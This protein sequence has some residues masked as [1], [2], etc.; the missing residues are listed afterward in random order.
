MRR[1]EFLGASCS[2]AGAVLSRAGAPGGAGSIELLG[3][4]ASAEVI[5]LPDDTATAEHFVKA[6]EALTGSR[7]EIS[8]AG[9]AAGNRAAVLIGDIQ[10][11]PQVC[12][13]AGTRVSRMTPESILLAT[14]EQGGRPVLLVAGGSR[15]AT[16]G[17]VGEL[18]NFRLETSSGRAWAPALDLVDTPALPYRIFWNWDHSTNWVRGVPGEQTHGCRNPYKKPSASYLKDFRRVVDYMAEHKLNG[19][20]LWG[21]LRD[22]HGGVQDA[23]QLASYAADRGVRVLPGI[24]TSHY[25]GFYYDGNHRFRAN[26]WLEQGREQL[27]FLDAR[28]NRL[29]DT[30][31]PTQPENQRWLREGARWLFSEMP[32]LGGANLENGDWMSCQCPDCQRARANPDNDPNYYFDM[33]H[34]QL[35]IIEEAW[36]MV[37]GAWMTYATYTGFN[38]GEMWKRTDKAQVRSRVPRFVSQYPERA[39]CQWTY[40]FMVDGW[41]RQPEAAVRAKWPAGLR[42]PTRHS[43][44]LL[45][46]GSQWHD[47]DEWWTKSPR[48]EATGQRYVDVS[49]LIRYTCS[50]CHQEG[51]EGIE[52]QGEVSDESPANEL[53]YLA[54]EEFTWHPRRSYE[55]FVRDRLSRIYGGREEARRYLACVRSESRE[56]AALRK[57]MDTANEM[58]QNRQFN[59]RQRSRWANLRAELARR[60]AL[61]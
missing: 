9:F 25:G 28:G 18:L 60:I 27:R 7:L 41:G 48:G 44:G 3:A 10:T 13:L 17:A 4:G 46:Q 55:D 61:L 43:I 38:A 58:S 29:R 36:K 26:T 33:M 57:D 56:F 8:S 59:Y 34:T 47:S 22:S 6:V 53:N 30:I 54:F 20:I 24:G 39:V 52:I 49:E 19:L 12:R 16:P 21:F 35:P 11:N 14:V 5:A 15:A 2:G 51:L 40:T 50:R 31:C 23:K 1:R 45:H 42:P 32:R 37:P